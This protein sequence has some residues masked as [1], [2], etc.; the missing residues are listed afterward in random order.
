VIYVKKKTNLTEKYPKLDTK[1]SL[2]FKRVVF[3]GGG[4]GGKLWFW[5]RSGKGLE[6][7]LRAP[8]FSNKFRKIHNI[9]D[10][11]LTLNGAL[12][13]FGFW[14]MTWLMDVRLTLNGAL[15]F[16]GFG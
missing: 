11:R 9:P 13:F 12:W 6:P 4:G 3:F 14:L 5:P 1:I 15:W 8:N 16:F 2:L 7:A 10:V